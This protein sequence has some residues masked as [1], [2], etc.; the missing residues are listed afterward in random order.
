MQNPLVPVDE[1]PER[2]LSS[3]VPTGGYLTIAQASWLSLI[4]SAALAV[5]FPKVS[6]GF[7]AWVAFVPLY[8]AIDGA[9]LR[10]V[11]W[12]TWLQQLVFLIFTL[13][14]FWIPL[15]IDGHKPVAIAAGVIVFVSAAEALFGAA[16][17]LSA[18][19]V[20]RRLSVSR[21]ISYPIAWAALEWVR[22]FFPVGFPWNPLGDAV[23]RE[24]PVIQV[25]EFI[26]VFGLSA[27]IIFVN[28]ALWEIAAAA[29]ARK[30][31]T[32]TV[33]ALGIVIASLVGFGLLRMRELEQMPAAG[34]LTV[35]MIQGNIPQSEKW[36]QSKLP[37][38]FK[39]YSDATEA[40]ARSRPDLI[41]WP[42]T[43]SDFVFQPVNAYP[44]ALRTDAPYWTRL[45]ALAARIRVPILFGAPA[46]DI[47]RDTKTR[48]RAYLLG[49]D[50]RVRGYYDK[51]ELVPVG[52]Y[53]PAPLKRFVKRMVEAPTDF[54]PGDRQTIFNVGTARIGVL[55]CYESIFPYLSQ[56]VAHAG[57]NVLVNITNDAW[58]GRSSAPYQLLAM[59]VMRAVENRTPIVRV[60]NSGISAI[61]TP[62]G[63]I[64][65][66]TQLFKR[67]TEIETVEWKSV[68]AFYSQ[69][70][71]VFAWLCTALLLAGLLAAALIAILF[72]SGA[73]STKS[74]SRS[75]IVT[76]K[77]RTT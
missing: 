53:V 56:R 39:I 73:S 17:V 57:A 16:S 47:G 67:T 58:Y 71:D 77:E 40:A 48:N 64:Q 68:R 33:A 12:L 11:F 1:R 21:L 15:H 76:S 7:L 75:Q 34:H 55:I 10:R 25:A 62:V 59:T 37:P 45:T 26:G 18:E 60:A 52:E 46:L 23:F 22:S 36:D 54:F 2:S 66:A 49:A 74:L 4:S 72:G 70:G 65:D 8:F 30:R 20:S 35:A 3:I 19:F 28:V 29:I 44:W 51:I 41:I 61:I 9:R 13:Y 14:W 50:G 31:S 63:R 27:L 6:I 32:Q 42:E 69:A 5:A 24:I 38:T 43:A